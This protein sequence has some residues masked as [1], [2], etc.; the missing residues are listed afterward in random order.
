MNMAR[1]L[2]DYLT[3]W[4]IPAQS[5]DSRKNASGADSDGQVDGENYSGNVPLQWDANDVHPE[6]AANK[7]GFGHSSEVVENKRGA[8]WGMSKDD[9]AR[10]YERPGSGSRYGDGR[11][12][13]IPRTNEW[14]RGEAYSKAH[15]NT[16]FHDGTGNDNPHPG[17]EQIGS[18]K[19]PS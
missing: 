17:T 1:G 3:D 18:S 9:I 7:G 16:G 8:G 19:L 6:A 4:N 5:G 10:G 14:S 13:D 11:P 15:P 12:Q 2:T